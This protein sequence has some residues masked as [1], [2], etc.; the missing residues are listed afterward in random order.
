MRY[1]EISRDVRAGCF[2]CFGDRAH[3]HGKN[4]QA[5]AARHHDATGHPT[6]CEVYMTVYYGKKG[7]E[8]CNQPSAHPA[9]SFQ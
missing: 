8:S 7:D 2:E 9:A 4:A 3:W 5:V 1:Y 6:W